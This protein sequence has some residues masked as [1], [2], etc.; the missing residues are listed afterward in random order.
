MIPIEEAT[1]TPK[2]W[3]CAH[4]CEHIIYFT[5]NTACI[6]KVKEGLPCKFIAILK[7]KG[8]YRGHLRQESNCKQGQLGIPQKGAW[9]LGRADT[10]VGRCPIPSWA[11][12]SFLQWECLRFGKLCFPSA[13]TI[14]TVPCSFRWRLPIRSVSLLL[15][16]AG[17]RAGKVQSER[18]CRRTIR[19][20]LTPWG[21]P[22][23]TLLGG[24]IRRTVVH[25]VS[26]CYPSDAPG[27]WLVA[28]SFH[29]KNLLRASGGHWTPH[30]PPEQSP[31]SSLITTGSV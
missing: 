29:N 14:R 31:A 7:R 22:P 19:E 30:L 4:R 18:T 23:S 1:K 17:G 27:T 20:E 13:S 26:N 12:L 16:A 25:L 21:T 10:R 5:T 11:S 28:R 6:S 15:A 9:A 8:V 2:Y 3:T 24:H